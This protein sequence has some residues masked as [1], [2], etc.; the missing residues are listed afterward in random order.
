MFLLFLW[1]S[2]TA[3]TIVTELIISIKVIN[4][5]NNIGYSPFKNGKCV[6]TSSATGQ[7]CEYL[8]R[9]NPYAHKKPEKVNASETRKNH[10][11]NFP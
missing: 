10:I 5:T 8:K 9:M 4:A 2:F 6:N 3:R 7:M 1:P 11:I